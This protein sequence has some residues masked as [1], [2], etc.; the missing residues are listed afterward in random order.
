MNAQRDDRYS[1][2]T[3]ANTTS[4][5]I[6]AS[7]KSDTTVDTKTNDTD[8][9]TMYEVHRFGPLPKKG[10][11]VDTTEEFVSTVRTLV[12]MG[13]SSYKRPEDT[14]EIPVFLKKSVFSKEETEKIKKQ[15]KTEL[16]IKM[17]VKGYPG[18]P[19]KSEDYR[20]MQTITW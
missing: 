2:A 12:R 20:K 7:S 11:Y 14:E 19:S 4:S 17:T 1:T 5:A 13:V 18:R 8:S 9:G 6:S 16:G 15:M 3:T 10:Y